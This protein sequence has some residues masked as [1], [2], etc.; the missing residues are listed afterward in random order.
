MLSMSGLEKRLFLEMSSDINTSY[1]T[2]NISFHKIKSNTLFNDFSSSP[3][4]GDSTEI[5][6]IKQSAK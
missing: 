4:L 1:T 2:I 3:I 6:E 5:Y